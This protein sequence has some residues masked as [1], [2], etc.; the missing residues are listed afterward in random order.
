MAHTPLPAG[1]LACGAITGQCYGAHFLPPRGHVV[2]QGRS[3][4]TRNSA[5][6]KSKCLPGG[7]CVPGSVLG[8]LCL[9]PPLVLQQRSE[10]ATSM[11]ILLQMGKQAAEVQCKRAWQSWDA[12]PGSPSP[13]RS[14]PTMPKH[15]QHKSS[16]FEDGCGWAG[17]FI[18]HLLC[19]KGFHIPYCI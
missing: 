12:N 16:P 1:S 19:D 15:E 3:Y 13:V 8:A 11:T 5:N 4:H 18:E 7:S 9:A 14:L 2:S 10:A 6:S 17:L